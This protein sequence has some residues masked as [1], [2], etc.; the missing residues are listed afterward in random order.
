MQRLE[1]L[2]QDVLNMIINDM[3]TYEDRRRLMSTSA[4]WVLR[5]RIYYVSGVV[6]LYVR[7]SVRP[8]RFDFFSATLHLE[9]IIRT[10]VKRD[11]NPFE[12]YR[13]KSDLKRFLEDVRQH[14]PLFLNQNPT[15]YF[16]V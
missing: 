13:A 7:H 2:S 3:L 6:R 12:W 16:S 9:D 4:T 14:V 5:R 1:G 15:F 10:R 11:V 8:N